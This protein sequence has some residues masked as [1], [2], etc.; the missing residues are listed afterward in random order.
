MSEA[1]EQLGDFLR[2]RR[3]RLRPEQ[4][5][6]SST[7]RR[8]TAGLRR[9]E[10]ANLAG[11]SPE[12]YVKLEQGRAVT[13]SHATTDALARA[14]LLNETEH[15][16]LRVLA[17]GGKRPAH[18]RE[19]VPGPIARLVES[20]SHPAY[21]TGRRWDVLAWNKA[22]AELLMDF[23]QSE[24]QDRNIL[25]YILT[26]PRARALFGDRW[27]EEARRT[28]AL[29][30]STHDLWAD[31]PAFVELV[32][33]LRRLCPEFEGW[34]TTHAVGTAISGR[35]TLHH[36]IHGPLCFEY[37]TF[38]ANDDGALKLT[39]YLPCEPVV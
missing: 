35:K 34:W 8:R 29:F 19:E 20:L 22:A 36:P 37:T 2:S 16:H 14:L 27:G 30:R 18:E 26:D 39:V 24:A 21:V 33:R 9:E 15:A 17:R 10:V 4:L 13:P 23:G 25:L 3:E 11:I 28:V 7:R 31:D 1:C 12:W 32:S 6:L 5:G 38:Q